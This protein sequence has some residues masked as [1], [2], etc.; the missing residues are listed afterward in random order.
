VAPALAGG[1]PTR[2]AEGMVTGS[3]DTGS[4]H[5]CGVR[6]GGTIACWGNN[7]RSQTSAPTG[8]FTQIDAGLDLS[9]GVRIDATLACWGQSYVFG[10][11]VPPAGTF[12]QVALGGEDP[13]I[14][15]VAGIEH[16][17]AIRTDRTL[18]CWGSNYYGQTAAPSG[19]FTQV[20]AGMRHNCAIRTD[21]TLACW[22]FNYSG[23]SNPPSGTFKQVAA[24]VDHSCAVRSDGTLAC[25][26]WNVD[27]QASPPSGTFTHVALGY[28]TS[29]ATRTDGTLACWGS[30]SPAP[31]SGTFTQVAE[32]LYPGG[33]NC[34]IRTDGTVAC[35]GYNASGQASPPAGSFSSRAIDAGGNASCA[36][37][38]G[39]ALACWGDNAY[40]RA[41]APAGSFQQV[42]AGSYHSCGLQSDGTAACWGS[43]LYGQSS[44]PLGMFSQVSAGG[45]HSCAIK[46]DGTLACWGQNQSGQLSAPSGT[47]RQVSAGALH[48]CALRSDGTLA[49]WGDNS[50][51]EA[52]PPSGTFT[53]VSAGSGR[54]CGIRSDGTIAC[55]GLAL[56]SPPSGTFTQVSVGSGHACALRIDGTIACWGAN[57]LGQASPP[58][59]TFSAISLGADHSCA[60]TDSGTPVCWGRNSEAQ[61]GS[62]P[63]ITSAPPPGGSSAP[64]SYAYTATSS[65]SAHYVVTA[66]ALPSGLTLNA[67]TGVLSGTPTAQGTYT[68]TV[69][70]SND[71]FG[72]DDTQDF[73][74][75]IDTIAPVTIDN[76]PGTFQYGD[77]VVTLSATDNAG[78]SGVDKT[79][80][81]KGA[82]PTDPTTAS[83]V[84]DATSKPTLG[85]GQQIKYFSTDNAGN[86][87][88]VKSSPAAKVDKTAPTTTDNVPAAVQGSD[89]SVTLTAIDN[90]GGSGVDKT[91]YSKGAAPTD[92]TTASAVYDATSKPTL[93]DGERIKYFSTDHVGNQETIKSSAAAKVDT[94]APTTT[95]NVP[96]A[97]Q[98]SHVVV[99]LSATDNAGGAGVDKTYFTKGTAPADPT[100]ASGVY[101]PTSKPT[102]GDGER[103][104]YFST[105]HV[106]NQESVK[107]SPAA[108]VDTTP[109]VTTDN[110]PAT[111]QD[112]DVAVTLTAT[113]TDGSGVDKTYYTKGVSP[114]GPTTSSPVYDATS[115]PTLGDGEQIKY[116]STD[117]VA[118]QETVKS[119]ASAKVDTTPPTT[120][121]NVPAAVQGSDVSVTLSATDNA[122]G[123]GVDKTYFTKGV[124]PTDP[125]TASAV[126]DA[127]SKPTLGDGEQIKYFSTDQVGN[128]ETV[129]SSASTKV[130]T[131]PPVT[132]DN[133]PATFQNGDVAVTLTAT[134]TDGS[135][136]DKTYFTKGTAP[137]D[138]TTA[139]AV[140][141]ATNKPTL[142]DGEQI[143]Y[144]STDQVGN[145]EAVK[146]SASANVDTTAPTTTDNVPATFQDSDLSVTLTATDNAGGSGIDKTYFTKGTAPTDPTTSSPVYDAASKP[147][148]G[149]GEQ[150][151]YFSTDQVGN[152]ESIK[153]SASANVDTTPPTTTDNVPA[154]F[155]DSDVSV[156]LTATD[157]AGGSGV[158]T[159]YYATGVSPAD[160]TTS[161]PIYDATN[162]PTL[163]DGEQIKYFSTDQV[164]NQETVKTSPA[165]KVDTTSPV[166]TD[167]VPAAV[168]G[169]DVVVTLS[170]TDNAGGSGVD[171]TYYTTGTSPADPTTSSAVYDAANKPTLGDG[172]Q[173]KYLSTDQAGNRESVKTSP[174]A[175][176]DTTPPQTTIDQGPSGATGSA[177]ASF[178]FSTSEPGTGSTFECQLDAETFVACDSPKALTSLS[179]GSHTFS[180]RAIDAA[181][182]RDA[183][184]ATRTWLVDT[185]APDTSIVSGPSGTTS[186]TSATFS[187]A[188]TETDS[189]FECRLDGQRAWSACPAT[190]D[191]LAEHTHTLQARAVDQAGNP[192]TSPAAR[193]WTIDTASPT[194]TVSGDAPSGATVSSG[195][196]ASAAEPIITQVTTPNA[197]P[198]SITEQPVT[199]SA[200]SGYGIFGQ[201]ISIS[202]P[203]ATAADPLVLVFTF[204]ASVLPPGVTA[205]SV[206]LLRNGILV[207]ECTSP[208]S[209]TAAPDPCVEK[210]E[211]L[212]RGD[213]RLT[214]LTS[215]ASKWNPAAASTPSGVAPSGGVPVLT[216]TPTVGQP[217]QCA[218]GSWQGDQ[219]QSHSF[220]WRRDATTIAGSA[221]T[222]TIG[223]A[224]QGHR[225][226]CR[227]TATN[228]AGSASAN[229]NSIDVA[230]PPTADLAVFNESP[231]RLR[232]SKSGRFT[233]AFLATPLHSGSLALK[234]TKKIKRAGKKQFMKLAARSFTASATGAAKVTFKLSSKN[235][236]ALKRAKQVRFKLTV[237][238][239]G[240]TFTTELTL[241][242]PKKS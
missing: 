48:S 151:K 195:E 194:Q 206:A 4:T 76:V 159:T 228:L 164:G 109:P 120:T 146:T 117:Q 235:R 161:S 11:S 156:T 96:E 13:V 70:A 212:P 69:T 157:N 44:P 139:S 42:S 219:P 67:A 9:C 138:P 223:P 15:H 124:A 187:L 86:H 6:S 131:T 241:K 104:K 238:I 58:S 188:S 232:V 63:Q 74:I 105:D 216:G 140:Y 64:Y 234:S 89:V 132:T 78:G 199:Q 177:S 127:T 121:D 130:D 8:T 172:E 114:A 153:T 189:S 7:N 36:V 209:T 41:S 37:K 224:D 135:G 180:V 142:G 129:K 56:P 184:P 236:N 173:I 203:T 111:F 202:A 143:K 77:V 158:D 126:Y 100:T 29:C 32:S 179:E 227:V 92:P 201:E 150:I 21:G 123:S 98:N 20:A 2:S 54:S 28:A 80:F 39:G 211:A 31:P 108:K 147:T 193:T 229:S 14:S 181:G 71:L 240:K 10:M 196:T 208:N 191:V 149:D 163:G 168:Q 185:I 125:T 218:P 38:A 183:S 210:R 137:T 88:A 239:G 19:A 182:N 12:L 119:S 22:G 72:P 102:L 91:Y 94:T 242:R 24:G 190:Y 27:G 215:H 47:F 113:D 40:G 43:D 152:Q 87:E 214:V 93:G 68:G 154:T 112:G 171:K 110:V 213:V 23:E 116:F 166:T 237:V 97:F 160:P 233:Y 192:D 51:G 84:Y 5:S 79:Y 45:Y 49:C 103:I 197:G 162:K 82:A 55:W 136:V 178:A 75:A 53:R 52:S 95:D 33:H 1:F 205:T 141:D 57:Q 115:K 200:P 155:Q 144:F 186:S 169:S 175:N 83:A 50:N 230:A 85:D 46:S 18:A 61:L 231:K 122:G 90:A 220:Q 133:V 107:T 204:D 62:A 34:A 221:V 176:V 174:A 66:G 226:S 35:W 73:S 225:I 145:Q 101:D 118:N 59:G 60:V 207:G 170:A 217:L 134:D 165:A 148:L 3:V 65:P 25:W 106:G 128:Q 167:D 16:A 17:C 222:H 99:T 30:T 26:G 198:V 81:T